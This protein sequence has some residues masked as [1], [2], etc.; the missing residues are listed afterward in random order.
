MMPT[1]DS[2]RTIQQKHFTFITITV[3]FDLFPLFT[4]KTDSSVKSVLEPAQYIY[5]KWHDEHA[6]IGK[7]MGGSN[8]LLLSSIELTLFR[9]QYRFNIHST[10]RYPLSKV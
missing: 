6:Y 9:A 1:T 2:P 7:D 3:T 10:I 5:D 4:H 8:N